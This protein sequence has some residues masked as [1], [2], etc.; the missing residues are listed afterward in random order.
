[1]AARPLVSCFSS[2]NWITTCLSVGRPQETGG[3]A[4]G[5][6]RTSTQVR[7][8]SVAWSGG[9]VR[10]RLLL[11]KLPVLVLIFGGAIPIYQQYANP[12]QSARIGAGAV[13][14]L[15]ALSSAAFAAAR[16]LEE[17]SNDQEGFLLA[18]EVLLHGAILALTGAV[19]CY[20]QSLSLFKGIWRSQPRLEAIQRISL[21]LIGALSNLAA[22]ILS[23]DGLTQLNRLLWMRRDRRRDKGAKTSTGNQEAPG[24]SDPYD[25][26]EI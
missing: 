10:P 22:L 23:Y 2:F 20:I 13:A 15:L 24:E 26:K 9:S 5:M 18:A 1:M 21:V 16:S 17:S 4:T 12:G 14:I 3:G 7:A 8:I 6:G 19:A 11:E 25:I